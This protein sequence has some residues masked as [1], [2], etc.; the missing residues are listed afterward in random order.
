MY[1]RNCGSELNDNQAICLK[2]GVKVGEGKA[3][4]ANC[5]QPVAENAA[6]CLSCGVAIKGA[7]AAAA[8][9]GEY[10]NGQNKTTMALICFF[11][12]GLGIH[13][14]MMGETKKGVFKII[15]SICCGIGAILALIDFVKI[16]TDKY[17]V[18]PEKLV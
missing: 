3:Y 11:L 9:N 17:E 5:G 2:C 13:N 16:L 14:F 10:L 7:G 6:V 15:M 4:C 12:G 8:G 1:C 18:N